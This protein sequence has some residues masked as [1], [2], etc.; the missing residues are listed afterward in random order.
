MAWF[1]D[2]AKNLLSRGKTAGADDSGTL[3]ASGGAKVAYH[4]T[5][6]SLPLESGHA[7]YLDGAL[8][9]VHADAG[10]RAVL[11][12][13][14]I[15]EISADDTAPEPAANATWRR[16]TELP[17][18]EHRLL[19]AFVLLGNGDAKFRGG[20]FTSAEA[21]YREAQKAAASREKSLQ[22]ICLSSLAAAVAMQGKH[23]QALKLVE[24]ALHRKPDLAEALYNKGMALL[25][26][27]RHGE[28]VP[29]FDEALVHKP[30]LAEAWY[31]KGIALGNLGRHGEALPCFTE[32]LG[33]GLQDADTWLGKGAA[34]LMLGLHREAIASFEEALRRRQGFAGAWL[35]KGLALMMLRR[36]GEALPCFDKAIDSQPDFAEAWVGKGQTLGD[37]GRH[38]AAASCFEKALLY[39][40]DLAHAWLNKGV[41][42]EHLGWW[43]QA[44][45]AHER[46]RSLE[47]GKK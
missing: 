46:A 6:L 13:V 47:K 41:A 3:F 21:A 10:I 12:R 18:E 25:H 2:K 9:Q 37:M 42:L 30:E 1:A 24:E 4:E 17:E 31:N 27:S 15:P 40:P 16:G 29:C 5:G 19:T 34:Q 14:G 22:S 11:E 8:E 43:K 7:S 39:K 23:D 45:A 35:G 38:E 36:H 26:F 20:Y 44:L 28:A 33:R 32:A